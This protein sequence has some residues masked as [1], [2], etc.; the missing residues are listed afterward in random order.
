MI[1]VPQSR[2]NYG[3]Q[4]NYAQ[5][6]PGQQILTVPAPP[7]QASYSLNTASSVAQH[8]NNNNQCEVL[9]MQPPTEQ[10]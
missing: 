9:N 4:V 10:Y 6:Y 8:A 1:I 5:E 7:Y 2:L 3:G